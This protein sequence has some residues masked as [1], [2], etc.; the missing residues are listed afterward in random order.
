MSVFIFVFLFHEAFS[1]IQNLLRK[2]K[3]SEIALLKNGLGVLGHD[4]VVCCVT[5]FGY[6]TIVND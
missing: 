4:H 5:F 1:N 3:E 2:E 6:F